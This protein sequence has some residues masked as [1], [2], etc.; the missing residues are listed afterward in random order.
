MI[1]VLTGVGAV[2]FGAALVWLST[3]RRSLPGRA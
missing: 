2:L 1:R 3:R